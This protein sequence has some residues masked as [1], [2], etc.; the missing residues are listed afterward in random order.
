M[1]KKIMLKSSDDKIFE[2]D[3]QIVSRSITIKVILEKEECNSEM[4]NEETKVVSLPHVNSKILS[5]VLAW[6]EY[7]KDDPQ[8]MEIKSFADIMPWD[9]DFLKVDLSTL[10][11][12]AKA[13]HYLKIKEL[14]RLTSQMVVNMLKGKSVEEICMM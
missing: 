12:M 5:K 4:K 3:V 6:A 2:T 8:P 10:F 13:A 14:V 11:E 1:P 7:H 9:A